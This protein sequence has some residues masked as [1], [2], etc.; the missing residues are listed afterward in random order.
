MVPEA[1]R[2]SLRGQTVSISATAALIDLSEA[3]ALCP[4][5]V[6]KLTIVLEVYDIVAATT[7]TMHLARAA[8]GGSVIIPGSTGTITPSVKAGE[9]DHGAVAVVIQGPFLLKVA[10]SD[11]PTLVVVSDGTFKVSAVHV[12]VVP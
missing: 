4:L 6:S 1:G 5:A 7:A 2:Y 11:V 10:A 9:T 12:V 3:M 8:D